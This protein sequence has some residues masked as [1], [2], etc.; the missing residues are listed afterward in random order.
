[1]A[2]GLRACHLGDAVTARGFIHEIK[3]KLDRDQGFVLG[4]EDDAFL[5]VYRRQ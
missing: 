4:R 2:A 1:V 5:V 3:V